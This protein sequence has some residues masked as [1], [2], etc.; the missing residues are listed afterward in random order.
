M[1]DL[2]ERVLG[3]A[4][5]F[6]A[7]TITGLVDLLDRQ[8]SERPKRRALVLTGDRIPMS[9]GALDALV[10]DIAARLRSTGLRRGD[11]IGLT[12]ANTAEF[13]VGLL[14]AA[15]AGLVIAPL[16]PALP[17]SET[18]ARLDRLGAQ[19]VILGP[20]AVEPAPPLRFRIAT[21]EL[22]VDIAASGIATAALDVGRGLE[23]HPRGAVDDLSDD[24]ALSCSPRAQ[25]TRPKWSR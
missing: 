14:G 18:T 1:S 2:T 6:V 8:V 15:R 12:S 19:A 21:W 11:A 13:V 22:R 3:R 5:M 4:H 9:Y 17:T 24:D 23:R 16:D 7:P 10:N 20:R 25:Q